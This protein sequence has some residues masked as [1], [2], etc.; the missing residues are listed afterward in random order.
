[1]MW[2]YYIEPIQFIDL[3]HTRIQL[4]NLG[5]AGWEM[6]ALQPPEPPSDGKWPIG[7]FKRPSDP[8]ESSN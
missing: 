4:N 2:E 6:I 3:E 8:L 1:M 7:I 5:A